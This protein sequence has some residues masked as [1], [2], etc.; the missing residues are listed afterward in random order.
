MKKFLSCLLLLST[1]LCFSSTA[2]AAKFSDIKG[3][4]Y[5]GVVERIYELGIVNGLS[6]TVFAPNKSVTRAEIA[7]MLVKVKGLDSYAESVSLASSFSDVPDSH[8]GKNYIQVAVDL[9]LLKGYE[10]GTFKP[11]KE[12]SYAETIAIVLR[13]LGYVN[14]DETSGTSWYSGYVKRMY[15]IKLDKGITGITSYTAPAKRGDV[16]LL[17]WNML[18]SDSWAIDFQNERSGLNYT[19]SDETQLEKLY[20]EHRYVT[21]TITNISNG[22]SGDTIAVCIGGVWYNTSSYVPIVALGATATAIYDREEKMLYGLSI[23]DELTD[24]KTVAGPIFYLKELGY[25]VSSSNGS[26]YGARGNATY[27]ILLVSKS[28]NRIL[29]SVLIDAKDSVIVDS[30]K[31]EGDKKSDNDKDKDDEDSSK[32]KIRNVYLNGNNEEEDVFTTTNAVV[33]VNGAKVEWSKI[34]KGAVL[35]TLIKGNLY[36]YTTTSFDGELTNYDN[37]KE[38]YVDLDKYLVSSNCVYTIAGDNESGD[39]KDPKYYNYSSLTKKKL[40]ELLSRK[41]TFYLNVAGE[42]SRIAFGRYKS[43]NISDKYDNTTYRLGYIEKITYSSDDS[44]AYI[45]CVGIDG[46]SKKYFVSEKDGESLDIGDLVVTEI[47]EEKDI[48]DIHYIDKNVKIGSEIEIVYNPKDEYSNGSFGEYSIN[49]STLVYKVNKEYAVNSTDKIK[50]CTLTK[51]DSLDSLNDLSKYNYVLA[52]D[53]DKNVEVVFVETEVN[54]VKYPI[55]RVVSLSKQKSSSDESENSSGDKLDLY[56]YWAKISVI[57]QGTEEYKVLNTDCEV[58][59][60]VT[61]EV[62]NKDTMEVKE[63]FKLD[64]IGYEKDIVIS[65]VDKKT[66]D[67]YV[68]GTNSVI[69]LKG[70]VFDYNGRTYDLENYNYIYA[71]VKEDLDDWR[72]ISAN[73]VDKNSFELKADDRLAFDELNGTVVIY[74]GYTD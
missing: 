27:A 69:N 67:A 59:E 21:G 55:A 9:G 34:P 29:R 65:S 52:C 13:A 46:K 3:T 64:V 57:G 37:L 63:R 74:R 50:S 58:G 45:T 19:Y 8:W 62:A 32:L 2:Y 7:K 20:P 18:V 56:L 61:F 72:F 49:S 4:S 39:S 40:E 41:T 11:D 43:T 36:T 48:K 66:K 5:E 54:K 68:K 10:D 26:V 30:V 24:Y 73:F 70:S 33:I 6:D 60:L 1:L 42:I 25:N 15:D 28:N 44:G 16:A 22:T 38:L 35:T 17:W 23:D 31:V 51:I 71:T 14:I 47:N 12:V 53:D